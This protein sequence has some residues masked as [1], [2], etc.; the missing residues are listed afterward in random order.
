M[1][2]CGQLLRLMHGVVDRR[3][4]RFIFVGVRLRNAQRDGANF[5]QTGFQGA[6][7][8]TVEFIQLAQGHFDSAHRAIAFENAFPVLI[9]VIRLGAQIRRVDVFFRNAALFEEREVLRNAIV[10]LFFCRCGIFCRHVHFD[11]QGGDIRNRSN[12][13]CA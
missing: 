12:A 2:T 10:S 13:C 6:V 8:Q 7:Q 5:V 4:T 9:V 1:E 3:F 11:R